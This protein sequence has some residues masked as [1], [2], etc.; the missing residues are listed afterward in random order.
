[1]SVRL[2]ELS[3]Y[4]FMLV[5]RQVNKRQHFKGYNKLLYWMGSL[6]DL[7]IKLCIYVQTFHS[8]FQ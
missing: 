6:T 7:F 2:R 5:N 8:A 3:D 1:M 4:I